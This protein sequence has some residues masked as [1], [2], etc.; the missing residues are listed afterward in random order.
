MKLKIWLTLILVSLAG[1]L[2][3]YELYRLCVWSRIRQAVRRGRKADFTALRA[4]FLVTGIV[5][6]VFFWLFVFLIKDFRGMP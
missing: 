3:W 6:Q 4:A 1:A 2:L 5:P